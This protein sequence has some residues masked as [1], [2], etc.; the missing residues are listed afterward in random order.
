[1][2]CSEA[3]SREHYRPYGR[4][5]N[6][7]IDRIVPDISSIEIY[8]CGEKGAWKVYYRLKDSD[9]D[10]SVITAEQPQAKI[11]G[12]V[13]GHDYE[14]F[15]ESDT[16][17][18]SVGYAKV[19]YVPGTVV[20]YLHP[21]D[22]RYSFSGRCLCTPSILIHP[23]GYYLASMDIFEGTSPQNLTLI[24]RSDD[25]GETWYHLTELFPCFWGTL[26]LHKGD[27]YML[28]TSTEYGDLL[29]GRSSDGGKTW[30][31]PTVLARGSC[32]QV[33][34][35]WH[36]SG[37]P[38]VECNGRLWCGVDYG[39]HRS[40]GH[41]S[42]LVSADINGDLLDADSWKITEPLKYDPNWEGAVRGD[43][44]GFIEGNAV[45]SPDGQICNILRYS[46]DRGDPKYGL[47]AFLKG[48][49]SDPDK[50]LDF[51][52]FIKFEGNLSKFDIKRDEKSGLYFTIFS[53]I[54]NSST[55]RMRNVLS[56][57]CSKDLENWE[58]VCDLINYEDI[59]PRT[60]GFQYVSFCFDGDDIIYLCRTA[61]N[62]AK[63]FHDSNYI[64]FHRIKEFRKM[65]DNKKKC[66]L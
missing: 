16:E 5:N 51:Y 37:M 9:G 62:G 35:G 24:F 60:V 6:L 54:T 36:K 47:A 64:T 42:C 11:C 4:H 20:N 48:D 19:G 8:W 34:P 2:N 55:P 57:A 38:V 25:K 49:K 50:A 33:L 26:F 21:D 63:N 29:V 10:W 15:V 1:M 40:G 41:M 13:E 31:R 14:F 43:E 3:W 32:H 65:I 23:E 56:L 30:G 58:T 59:D 46:T 61:F 12:L 28:G 7:M 18:S 22:L 66:T 52:R 53:R 39:S 27:V 44:R 17:K 45:V